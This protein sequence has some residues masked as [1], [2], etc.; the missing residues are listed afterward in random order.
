MLR[1]RTDTAAF[2]F[3][4]WFL[5]SLLLC[6]YTVRQLSEG[7]HFKRIFYTSSKAWPMIVERLG[8]WL[9][10]NSKSNTA[11]RKF[12]DS[13]SF[14]R[15]RQLAEKEGGRE[16]QRDTILNKWAHGAA[17]SQKFRNFKARNFTPSPATATA[18]TTAATSMAMRTNGA[19][20]NPLASATADGERPM[21]SGT[22]PLAQ[23]GANYDY[24]KQKRWFDLVH[25]LANEHVYYKVRYLI[26]FVYYMVHDSTPIQERVY[27]LRA[28]SRGYVSFSTLSLSLSLPFSANEF[29]RPGRTR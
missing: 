8:T 6:R 1:V 29:K 20:L 22:H 24:L 25:K 17:Y 5:C 7:I 21:H 16:Q 27:W 10:F 28:P 19:R 4:L 3:L 26:H 18:A 11:K 23:H 14:A 15:S 2:A 13:E 12:A 9:G